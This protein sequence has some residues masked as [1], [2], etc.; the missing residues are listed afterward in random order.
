MATRIFG[1]LAALALVL[2]AGAV[3]PP[4]THA[5]I[6]ILPAN[7]AGVKRQVV[8]AADVEPRV[9]LMDAAALVTVRGAVRAGD[10]TLSPALTRLRVEADRAV[11][12]GPYSVVTNGGIAPSGDPHDYVSLSIYWWPN[13]NT[14]NGLPY[15]QRD[16]QR[17]PQS[18]DSTFDERALSSMSNA[19]E[20]LAL[21]WYLTGSPAYAD[22]AATQ[23]RVWFLS[24]ETRMNP[25]MRFAGVI[26]GLPAERGVGIIQSRAFLR[27]AD[28]AALLGGASVWTAGDQAGLEGWYA[29]LLRW[30]AESNQGQMASRQRNN[31]GSWYDAQV[32][33]F[34][35]FAGRPVLASAVVEA[36]GDRRIARQ[37]EPDGRQ[38]EELKRTQ[39][40]TY[41]AFNLEALMALAT[42]GSRVGVDLWGYQTGD[43]R[44]LRPALDLLVPLADG[45][46]WPY[47]QS[48]SPEL[49]VLLAPL[50][51][52]AARGYPDG[53]YAALLDR[54]VPTL[55][56]LAQLK[57]RLGL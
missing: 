17:N 53:P 39:S 37:I 21:A 15:V 40:L 8:G 16:G 10:P 6:E 31:I 50:L 5:G 49:P 32:A 26:P 51:A 36:A 35:A 7:E 45:G 13:P 3:R 25:N 46:A 43:G 27:V 20:T 34:A 19:V 52:S 28:A 41:S 54:L 22:A 23:L 55:P 56:P 24:P 57:V 14:P 29:E 33:G 9:L 44:G 38:T 12:L 1:I 48:D 30:L 2:S 4:T 42:I 18:A 47:P 11:R